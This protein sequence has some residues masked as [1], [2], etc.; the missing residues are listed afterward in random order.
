MTKTTLTGRFCL[1]KYFIHLCRH[2]EIVAMQTLNLVR[3]PL[4]SDPAP[5]GDCQELLL[6]Q[7]IIRLNS[8]LFQDSA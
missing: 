3:P 8:S 4:Y 7:K 2:N 1:S 5:L 6:I